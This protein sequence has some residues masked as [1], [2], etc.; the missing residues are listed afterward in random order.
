M[1]SPPAKQKKPGTGNKSQMLLT[2]WASVS[3]SK[4]SGA[5]DNQGSGQQCESFDS[6]DSDLVIMSRELQDID[7]SQTEK[8]TVTVTEK[9]KDK[10]KS[11]AGRK[12]QP[13]KI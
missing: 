10:V 3:A 13:L 12:F 1:Q 4:K 7:N 9:S 2:S 5:S 6:L 11:A 8:E